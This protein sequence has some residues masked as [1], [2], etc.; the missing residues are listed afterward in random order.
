MI[1]IKGLLPI[2]HGRLTCTLR[3]TKCWRGLPMVLQSCRMQDEGR[4]RKVY[5]SRQC[6]QRAM[7][8]HDQHTKAYANG[9]HEPHDENRER[10]QCHPEFSMN[11]VD[12]RLEWWR[13]KY[14]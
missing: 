10:S 14:Q 1:D 3:E 12:S 9:E 8:G 2:Q 4:E 7:A 11:T 13:F 5:E 6:F